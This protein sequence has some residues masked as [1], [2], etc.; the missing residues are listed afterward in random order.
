MT[1]LQ[2]ALQLAERG[3]SVI[4]LL[5]GR[6]KPAGDW[7]AAQQKAFTPAQLKKLWAGNA[8]RNVGVV[9]GPISGIVVVDIDSYKGSNADDLPPTGV[10]QRTGRGG[11]Q[12]FYRH[13]GGP[14]TGSVGI[15]PGIDIRADGNFV[16][17][18]PSDT[19]GNPD[20]GG[21]GGPYTWI[22]EDW[23]NLADPP[24]WVLQRE[25][26]FT[27][28]VDDEGPQQGEK[29][30]SDLL[31]NGAPDGQ[32]N[33]SLTRLAGYYAKK[34]FV[35]DAA[36]IALKDWCSRLQ[37]PRM[38]DREIE[39]TVKSVY[40]TER[41][42]GRQHVTVEDPAI[43]AAGLLSMT[44]MDE[45]MLKHGG[46]E[47]KWTI[48]GWLPD[49]T[50]AMLVSPPQSYKTYTAF[51][52]AVSVASGEPFL[53]QFPVINRG[54]VAIF[55]QEDPHTN[56]AERNALISLSR[57]GLPS[58]EIE[59]DGTITVPMVQP[60]QLPIYFHEDRQL[61][62][63]DPAIMD[64]LEAFIAKVKPRLVIIDP[65]YSAADTEDYMAKAAQQMMRL[66][67]LR[68]TYGTSFI[69]VHHTKKTMDSWDR[70]KL[71]GSQFLNAFIETSWQ[72]RT[73][74]NEHFTI[75]LRHFKVA[76][77]QPFVRLS[78]DIE[79][80]TPPWRYQVTT[81][82]IS[83][84][85]AAKAVRPEAATPAQ[86]GRADRPNRTENAILKTLGNDGPM[87]VSELAKAM[88]AAIEDVDKG[89]RSLLHK[90]RIT[91]GEDARWTSLDIDVTD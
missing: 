18:A 27:V 20:N 4:A 37:G 82:E 69:I 71:W 51:D 44:P 13:P 90:H 14:V 74:P 7:L 49:A 35:F 32:R 23:D 80:E 11:L 48:K 57:L 88:K 33:G 86:A 54:P 79:D 63:D 62:F 60:G 15:R 66:K 21:E 42:K 59:E 36:L 55:Q 52:L 61:R 65:L 85:E 5:P 68:D 39:T 58:L 56:I 25:E 84:E 31:R 1:N 75:L 76:G 47:T 3:L 50:I 91:Q 72:M 34:G 16:A 17:V 78:F 70:E 64:A 83:A 26:S 29:W 46:N 24:E 41:K 43:A 40:A 8:N 30:V 12:Y 6:K 53:G 10:I 2:A 77:P 81:E 45:Y 22:S 28:E 89:L 87:T 67:T 38:S 73:P 9:T 19:T